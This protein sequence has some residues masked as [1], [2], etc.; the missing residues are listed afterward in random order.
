MRLH[1]NSFQTLNACGHSINLLLITTREHFGF[2]AID[3]ESVI[4]FKENSEKE[5]VCEF[6]EKIRERNPEPYHS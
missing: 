1:L 2:Y 4:D 5:S 3:G 6:L